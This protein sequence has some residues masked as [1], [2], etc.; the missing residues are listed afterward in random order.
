[1]KKAL[2]STLLFLWLMFSF[3]QLQAQNN[4]LQ[5]W[6][7]ANPIVISNFLFGLLDDFQCRIDINTQDLISNGKMNPD[8]SD[9]RFT[10]DDCC[11]EIPYWI[12]SGINTTQTTIW[13]R[14][15][16]VASAG[17][18]K[19]MMYYGNPAANVAPYTIDSVHFSMGNDS[20]G[21]DTATPGITV[22]TQKYQ[23]P[24]ELSTVRF[25]IYSWD[26]M[27]IKFKVSNDTNMVTGVTPFYNVPS[28][29]GFYHFD[30]ELVTVQ[31]GHIG[32]YTSTG[33][34]FLN[35][36]APATPCP[37]SCGD[38]VYKPLDQG[39]FGALKTDTC[40]VFPNMKVWYR[41]YSF[42]DPF[43]FPGFEFDRQQ[44]FATWSPG[45]TQMC[46]FDSLQIHAQP[47]QGAIG[48]QWYRDSILIPGA[49]DT[50]LM[51]HEAGNYYCVADFGDPCL[52]IASDTTTIQYYSSFLDLGENYLVCTD[53][54]HVI[55]AGSDY[56]SYQW[57]T[58]D[59]TQNLA[60]TQTGNYSVMVV[61]SQGCS[62]ADTVYVILR[63]LPNPVVTPNTTT[64]ICQGTLTE[65][66]AFDPHWYIYEWLPGH[67][68]SAN[69]FVGQ[70]GP[71][72]VVV[73]DSAGCSD[74]SATVDLVWFPANNVTLGP[75]VSFCTGDSATFD[76]GTSWVSIGWPDSSHS[77]F[78]TVQNPGNYVVLVSDSNGCKDSDTVLVVVNPLPLVDLGPSDSICANGT[79]TLDAGAGFATY[80][81]SNGATTQTISVG[82]GT[83]GVVVTDSF[84]CTNS[85]ELVY[86]IPYPTLAAPSIDGNQDLLTSSVAPNYQWLLNGVPIV[87]ANGP[88]YVPT[89]DGNYSVLVTDPY[90]C[91]DQE[92]NSI[93]IEIVLFIAVTADMIPEGF[94]PNGDGI[95]DRFE[96][97]HIGQYPNSSLVVINRWGS[98]VYRKSPYDNTFNGVSSNGK[99]LPDA[100]YFY[101]LDLGNGDKPFNGYLIINR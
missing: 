20:M 47:I 32:W 2:R 82:P 85:S 96:I 9:I 33:G 84:G 19:I 6:R 46:F 25:Q 101:I 26:T 37:G 95:N 58:G 69:V 18:S 88:T 23:F 34:R 91:Q 92:S 86:H 31:F 72:S 55:D 11:T 21:S 48:L 67:E 52:A 24:I 75:D 40:G 73:T 98:E 28:T 83:Y 22:A 74:T 43:T 70:P 68:T 87:N 59:T 54:G 57:N 79:R 97:Q 76:A 93:A 1:M 80:L 16:Q 65:F 14:V 78:Y 13:V 42:L 81:W 56:A 49:T 53:T 27:R 51:A 90:S 4:C 50:L 71:Y 94:S 89:Q 66:V 45:G 35:S 100:T 61:D 64:Y 7:Y 38:A 3:A 41:R 99:D 10:T 5:N 63:A 36:C 15:P 29:P 77:Q 62:I 60:I 12:Q 8:G 39:V 30:Y 17:D 44:P